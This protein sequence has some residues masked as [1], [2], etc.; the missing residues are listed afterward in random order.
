VNSGDGASG[1]AQGGAHGSGDDNEGEGYD[2]T[3]DYE[4]DGGKTSFFQE[5][6]V[7]DYDTPIWD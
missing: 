5:E 4:D 6:E 7:I 2:G 3:F 1:D